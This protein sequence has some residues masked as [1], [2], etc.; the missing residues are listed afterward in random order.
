MRSLRL[1]A[2]LTA[3]IAG[4]GPSPADRPAAAPATKPGEAAGLLNRQ[5]D[6]FNRTR[7]ADMGITPIDRRVG[8]VE[9]VAGEDVVRCFDKAG[10][11]LVTLTRR[12]DG[13]FQGALKTEYHEAA[14]P[15]GHSWGHVLAELT[16]PKGVVD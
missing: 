3:T 11:P 8:R 12:K 14:K 4:C 2:L 10:A 5:I 13:S 15:R 1:L 9:Y 6:E 16:L 7:P